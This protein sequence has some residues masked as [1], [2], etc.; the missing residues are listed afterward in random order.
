MTSLLDTAHP[1]H[2]DPM[3][4]CIGLAA[5]VLVMLILMHSRRS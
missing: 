4:A 3:T 2:V 5:V 1:M